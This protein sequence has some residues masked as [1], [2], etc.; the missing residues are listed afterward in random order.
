MAQME[1]PVTQ[2]RRRLADQRSLAPHVRIRRAQTGVT[3]L[4]VLVGALVV[5]IGAVG[6]AVMFASGAAFIQAEGD[7]RVTIQLAQERI[8]EIIAAGFG[9]SGPTGATAEPRIEADVAIPNHP[10]YRRTTAV[11]SVCPNNFSQ[12]RPPLASFICAAGVSPLAVV[13][14]KMFTVTV[15]AIDGT[16]VCG[17]SPCTDPKTT[18]VTLETVIL[19]H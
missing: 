2:M 8:Q 9:D 14:A 4:E 7:N 12:V 19:L 15:R 1:R 11:G 17:S 6:I 16:R 10:G 5:G 18:P 3:I 13:E